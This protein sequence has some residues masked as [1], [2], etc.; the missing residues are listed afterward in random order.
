MN[1]RCLS[2]SPGLKWVLTLQ[3][4]FYILVSPSCYFSIVPHIV[5]HRGNERPSLCKNVL[6]TTYTACTAGLKSVLLVKQ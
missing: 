2:K 1:L 4:S 3:E 6:Q 5:T